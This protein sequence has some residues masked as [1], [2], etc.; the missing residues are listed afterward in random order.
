LVKK[1][2]TLR[3]FGSPSTISIDFFRRSASTAARTSVSDGAAPA[4]NASASS[5]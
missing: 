4:A 3:R 2:P 1:D 5:R